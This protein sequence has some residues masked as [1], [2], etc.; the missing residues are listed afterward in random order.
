MEILGVRTERVWLEL[1]ESSDQRSNRV[2]LLTG[3]NGSGKSEIL[4]FLANTFRKP[5]SR[6]EKGQISWKYKG[7]HL[8]EDGG[9]NPYEPTRVIAQTYSPF[10]RF[11]PPI[12]HDSSLTSLYSEG[13]ASDSIYICAG[14]HKSTRLVSSSL[15]KNTLEQAIYRLS[16]SLESVSSILRVM[17]NLGLLDRI[18]FTY[19]ARIGLRSII[20]AN[21]KGQ[22]TE[23]LEGRK[24]YADRQK[25][26]RSGLDKELT[27]VS[28]TDLA[29]LITESMKIIGIDIESRSIRHGIGSIKSSGRYDFAIFQSLSLLRR[30]DLLM[31]RKC[32]LTTLEG[33]EFDVADA[34]SGQQQMLCSVI[35]LATALKN[36]SLVLIDEPELSLHPRWQQLYLENLFATLEPFHS[37]HIL[38]ATHSPLIVQRG[39]ALGAGITQVMRK[40]V[41]QSVGQ[42]VTSVEAT[43]Q[44]VF[45][46]PVFKSV[47]LANE[48]FSL[49]TDGEAGSKS[50]RQSSLAELEKLRKLYAD[51]DF[52]DDK[53]LALISDAID[54]LSMD[55]EKDA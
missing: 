55:M 40:A 24:R 37:C 34:S 17:T 36:G 19:E 44:D 2:D 14:L 38:I 6:P 23:Y 46:T 20:D 29:A 31:L 49:I 42:D 16:E 27:K 35:G 4:S 45:N 48:I 11:P 32:E 8:I 53:S 28:V 25:I 22:L 18:Y 33:N 21:R 39:Q 10:N 52:P 50:A 26:N 51:N 47:H 30:L 5:K 1:D 12:D 15:S 3:P 43:L 13:D 7:F 9:I 41:S 54:L